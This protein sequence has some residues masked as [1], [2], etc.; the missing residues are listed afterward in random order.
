MDF[1]NYMPED[2]LVKVDRASMLN[3]LEIRAPWLDYR[4]IE[5]A[6]AKVPSYRKA[7]SS[8]KKILPKKLAKKVLPPQF[9]LQRKQGFSIPLKDWLQNKEWLDYFKE[10][11][12]DSSGCFF[13]RQ[14]S[15][16]LLK[17]QANGRANNERLFA[18]VLLELWRQEYKISL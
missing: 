2:I 18:L 13:D 15:Q 3:S 17:G 7:T 5:F 6:F 9:D 11:L 12:L 16:M 14:F 4:L 8:Q 1:E 10:I